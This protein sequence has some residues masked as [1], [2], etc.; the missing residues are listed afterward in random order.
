MPFRGDRR[1]RRADEVA[2]QRRDAA[3]EVAQVSL[4]A[5]RGASITAILTPPPRVQRRADAAPSADS[6]QG[7]PVR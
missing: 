2:L 4:Q 7:E 5:E 6:P 3:G 1:I